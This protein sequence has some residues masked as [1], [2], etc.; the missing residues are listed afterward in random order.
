ML[1]PEQ[2]LQ[3]IRKNP[4]VPAPSQAVAKVLS[5]TQDQN[6]DTNKVADL[7]A[8]DSALTLQLLREVNSALYAGTKTTS[9]VKES[10]VRLGLKRVRAAVIN[11][12]V[13]SG[14]GKACPP[15]FHPHQYWQS[16]LAV[17][18]A[19]QDL[20]KELLPTHVEDAGTAGLLCDIGVGLLAYGITAQYRPLLD[21]WY[22]APQADL[23]RIEHRAIGITHAEV[24]AEI[25]TDWKLDPHLIE[26]VRRH[27]EAPPVAPPNQDDRFERIIAAAVTVSR[28]ALHGSDMEYVGRLFSQME[29]LTPK[30]DAVVNQL[31][32]K[33]VVHIQQSAATLA[34][35]IGS[36]Q[37]MESNFE[38]ALQKMPD[39]QALF[40]HRPMARNEL[41]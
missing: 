19:A 5:L 21:E 22:A 29:A 18:V 41:D 30:A 34:V 39:M 27:H 16:A 7:I 15:G 3:S 26:A 38:T 32:D 10:C 24:G 2:I 40:S 4:R 1:T 6:C 14:L 13:V 25:L 11:Q 23:E 35:E 9:S 17:S 31:L 37:E 20:C 8:R 33:L 36:T 12:H 28:I